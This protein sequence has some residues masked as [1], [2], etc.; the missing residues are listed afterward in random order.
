MKFND[1]EIITRS[2]SVPAAV[3]SRNELERL[4]IAILQN[5]MPVTKPVRLLGVSLSPLCRATT[6]KSRN[7]ACR[8]KKSHVISISKAGSMRSRSSSPDDSPSISR[9][10]GVVAPAICTKQLYRS[11][12]ATRRALLCPVLW[13]YRNGFVQVMRASHGVHNHVMR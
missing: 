11:V 6:R 12:N 10:T 7:S 4:S 3:S 13:V 5:E 2:R 1:F 9:R 8:S